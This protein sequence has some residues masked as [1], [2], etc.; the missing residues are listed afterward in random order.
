[1]KAVLV[2]RYGPPDSVAIVDLPQPVP[3]PGQVLVHIRAATVSAA[4]MRLRAGLFPRGMGVLARLAMGWRG[5]RQPVL[6]TDLAGE[7]AA[8]GPG[9]TEWRVGD[10]VIGFTGARMGC[11]AEYRVMAA[12]ALIARPDA[13]SWEEA[14]ALPFGF[15]TALFFLR[16]KAGLKAGEKV[17][18]IGASGAVGSAAVQIARHLGAGVTGVCSGAN[19]ALVAGLG[20]EVI[21][22]GAADWARLGR[23]WDVILDTTGVDPARA[24]ACLTP[25]GRLCLVAA[26]LPQMLR[27]ALMPRVFI[28]VAPERVADLRL[29][30]GWAAEGAV[31]P[32]AS[33]TFPL[34]QA[35]RAHAIAESGRK[36]GNVVLRP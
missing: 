21:D 11:H 13:L 16:D 4:D 33:A 6:G 28:G 23:R 5:P 7:V 35:A 27:A 9:V 32:V 3:G 26:D 29:L 34:D 30:A 25:T 2:R 14:A 1:M 31:K 36:V 20:A 17:L 8:L 18:V 15:T 24:R 12:D 22:Y 10:A 19:A